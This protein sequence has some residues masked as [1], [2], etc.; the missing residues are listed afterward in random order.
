MH[1]WPKVPW[2]QSLPNATHFTFHWNKAFSNVSALFPKGSGTNSHL[3]NGIDKAGVNLTQVVIQVILALCILVL[4]MMPLLA[5]IQK[6]QEHQ[7]YKYQKIVSET[8]NADMCACGHQCTG[9]DCVLNQMPETNQNVTVENEI[10]NTFTGL[11]IPL[12]HDVTPV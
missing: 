12:L 1:W 10:E 8:E 9:H 7:Q 2:N 11:S 3:H 6:Y 4:I 5:C